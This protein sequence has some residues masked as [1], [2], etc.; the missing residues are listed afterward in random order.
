MP[1]SLL[2]ALVSQFDAF[3]GHLLRALFL[4]R[5]EL[6][7]TFE[8]TLSL[9][10]ILDLGSID[11]AREYII[12]REID[13][14]IRLSHLDQIKW[15][16]KTL[17]VKFTELY[18]SMPTFVEIMERRNLFVHA[19]GVVSRHYLRICTKHNVDVSTQK[20]GQKLFV[21]SDYF[22]TANRVLLEIGVLL[23]HQV[24]RRVLKTE[25]GASDNQLI[26]VTFG[27]IK[28][29]KYEAAARMLEFVL[30]HLPKP[31]TERTKLIHVVNL[32]NAYRLL[33]DK[34]KSLQVLRREDWSARSYEFQLAHAV[35]TRDFK[36]GGELMVKIG[37]EGSPG[38]QGYRDWPLFSEFRETPEFLGAFERIFEEKF[39][40]SKESVEPA[41]Q[42]AASGTHLSNLEAASATT[43]ATAS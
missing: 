24:W 20:Q 43:P 38:K 31:E 40:F 29:S 22:D 21:A 5:P 9:K 23:A 27:L 1:R 2:T 12:E 18:D 17:K 41:T 33:N 39:A 42:D 30:E 16:E 14:I 34:D 37:K 28:R 36:L 6:V 3:I 11:E 19:D 25:V 10:E 15:F 4:A 7:N 26:G 8:S 32:A 13:K 35:L